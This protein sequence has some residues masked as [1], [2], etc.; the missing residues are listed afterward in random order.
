MKN[1]VLRYIKRHNAFT[2]EMQTPRK[3]CKKH[4]T[5]DNEHV[6]NDDRVEQVVLTLR[7]GLMFIRKHDSIRS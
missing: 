3:S 5:Q 7:D 6:K 4:K 2:P 1:D